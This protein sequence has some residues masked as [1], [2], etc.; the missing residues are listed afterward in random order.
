MPKHDDRHLSTTQLSAFIDK[1]LSE[2]ELAVCNAHLETCQQCQSALAGLKQTVAFLQAL[3]EPAL[4]RSFALSEGF[5]YLQERPERQGEQQ[6]RANPPVRRRLGAYYVQRSLRVASTIAAVIGLV[7]LLSGLL[8]MLPHGESASTGSNAPAASSSGQRPSLVRPGITS[9]SSAATA[10]AQKAASAD[11]HGTAVR[12]PIPSPTS[13]T[14]NAALTPTR[15]KGSSNQNPSKNT[16][17]QPSLPLLDLGTPLGRQEAGF[18][19]LVLGIVGVLL[20][21]RRPREREN[22]P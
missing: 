13:G 18:T 6:A 1:Q 9:T 14:A 17:T 11:Q 2:Q 12:T 4:P 16:S 22:Q 10:T 5:T 20:T 7:F 3:P 8:P 19:L 21:R 15:I